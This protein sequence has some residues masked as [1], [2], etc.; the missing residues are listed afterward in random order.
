MVQH[1]SGVQ[2]PFIPV[3]SNRDFSAQVTPAGHERHES[4]TADFVI[5]VDTLR[6]FANILPLLLLAHV[7]TKTI[8]SHEASNLDWV[9]ALQAEISGPQVRQLAFKDSSDLV[10]V[11]FRVAT[12]RTAVAKRESMRREVD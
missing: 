2:I 3:E 11:R 4:N 12:N 8:R 6:L 9:D 7:T 5:T 1:T 10:H